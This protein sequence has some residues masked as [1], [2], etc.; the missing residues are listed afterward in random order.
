MLFILMFGFVLFVKLPNEKL[1][2]MNWERY[3]FD[4]VKC[5]PKSAQF[6][7]SYKPLGKLLTFYNWGGYLIYSFPQIKPSI[8]GRMHLWR[9]K[10]GYSAFE[11]YYPLEQNW[12][13]IDKTDYEIVYMTPNKPLYQH[14]LALVKEKKWNLLY[15][16][17]YS[18]IFIRND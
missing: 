6:L 2:N 15:Q 7:A 4:F 18:G 13:D 8:D 11:E 9:D 10:N 14:L 12:K 16:D 3:C 17:D 1:L 5:S